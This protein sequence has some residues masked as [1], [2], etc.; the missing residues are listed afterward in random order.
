MAKL[1][2]TLAGVL[3]DGVAGN[4]IGEQGRAVNV[5]SG[6]GGAGI[7]L[8]GAAA[9]KNQIVNNY[10]G[11]G[12]DGSTPLGNSGAGVSFPTGSTGNTVFKNVI[13]AN[14]GAGVRDLN[15][16]PSNTFSQNSIFD[17][18]MLG[19][20]IAA[21]G[22]TLAGVPALAS[23][24]VGANQ[25]T[26][27]GT[28]ASQANTTYTLEFFANALRD[29]S[30]YGQ[31][32]TYLG[33]MNVT[34]DGNGNANFTAPFVPTQVPAGQFISATAT[35]P[36]GNTTEFSKDITVT[37]QQAQLP[38]AANDQYATAENTPLAVTAAGGVL[39]N[40]IDP[41][42]RTLTAVLSV[43]PA[44]GT[45]TLQADGSFTYTP[46]TNYNGTDSFTYYASDGLASSNTATVTITVT[47]VNQ[48]PVANPVTVSATEDTPLTLPATSLLA[49][50]TPGPPNESGQTLTVIA[51]GG[52]V[53]GVV[54][55]AGGTITFTPASHFTGTASFTY[56]IQDNGTTNGQPDP[57]TATAT[58][59][60]N[61]APPVSVATST[62]VD[63]APAPSVYGQPVSFTASVTPASPD[64]GP[65]TG[66]VQFQ[67]GGANFGT[68]VSLSAGMATSPSTATLPVGPHTITALYSGDPQH[69][70][71][72][73]SYTETVNATAT[74][75]T[76]ASSNPASVFGQPVT[77]T[78]DVAPVAPG[79]GTPTGMVAFK[80]MSPGGTVATLGM[81]PLDGTGT[82]VFNTNQ[83]V[84]TSYTIFA[85]YLGDANNASSTSAPI[86]QV[87]QPADT[88]ITLSAASSTVVSGQPNG[89]TENLAVVP[90]GSA[91]VPLTGTVT[92][93]DTFQGTT[94]VLGVFT[95]G[96]P[97]SFPALT[98]V[99]TH[100]LTAVYSGDGNYNGST[101]APITVVVQ[102]DATTST[103]SSSS[104]TAAYG[105]P[106][107]FTATVAPVAP[108]AVTPTGTV[109]LQ[110]D[111]IN[112]GKPALL[113][114][115]AATIPGIATLA[116]GPHTITALYSGDAQH[117]ASMGS[118]TE[119]VDMTATATTIASSSP[120]SVFGQPVTFTATVAPVAPGS[121]TPTGMVAFKSMSPDG[122]I[123]TTLGMSP[124]DATGT[125][126]FSMNQLVPANHTIF[127]VYLGDANNA[128]STSAP[129]TQA[130]QPANS[131]ITLSSA[132]TTLVLG[133]ANTLT[134]S[135]A[136][137]PPGTPVVAF[138][139][140]ITIYDT[141]QGSTTV[142]GVFSLGQPGTFPALTGVG[143]HVLTA[144]YSGD[145]N[146]NG[147][148]SA[149]INVVVQK[150]D[151]TI[152]LS[153]ASTTVVSGQANS[154][155]E[156]LAAV[157][158]GAAVVPF[159]GTIT[160]Y[161]TFQG[162]TTVLG[163]F[164]IGQP[165]SF[166]ALTGVGA[167][168]LTAVYSGDS[169]YNGS[170]SAPITVNVTPAA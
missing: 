39:A 99:G 166:P 144:V 106:V 130:V 148:T 159:T 168:V 49:T 5:I 15:G 36:K 50:D 9:T 18:A 32:K 79:G 3:I 58:V 113:S 165:G 147:S 111:G 48:P 93:H 70:A 151:T 104:P 65:P 43:S 84:P 110:V 103:V 77:F 2:N 126:V 67:V 123:V 41:N 149:P 88:T 21:Q 161:D 163:V 146:Y 62:A 94:T 167:H 125:A 141:F 101:S 11:T 72:T 20:D 14:A 30:G 25:T 138:T 96:Q 128:S 75:T 124:L 66:T 95:L 118:V 80:S 53:N 26:V 153:A 78:A 87:V 8:M 102:A 27:T 121:G 74:A 89:L 51:V 81:S 63:G 158:P 162:S 109:Q 152:T 13:A 100:V 129:I 90:P 137:V 35:D 56:T 52:A 112:L 37:E 54:A 22:P 156:S 59:T 68:P 142:V 97:G 82:A 12:L 40:D 86:T 24:V 23:A 47:P 69:T 61:V 127:A 155:T 150:A 154:L 33:S 134:E 135:L 71:S 6:N 38:K 85:V 55:L 105:E 132:S 164:T 143:T 42:G 91:V 157:P 108:G 145:S 114:G 122:T 57:K 140:T 19:I 119:T 116:V 98:V 76:V 10:I 64:L 28:L 169:H 4:F 136:V 92:I 34:T 45:L 139:G 46:N 60:V 16:A 170:T 29:P 120:T 107:S 7:S 117:T 160:L 83:L 44:D 1:G 31:G 17:N 133:Q 115:G 131:T 73:G